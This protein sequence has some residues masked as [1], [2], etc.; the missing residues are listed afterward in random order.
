MP[1]SQAMRQRRPGMRVRV[2]SSWVANGYVSVQQRERGGRRGG[3]ANGRT[4]KREWEWPGFDAEQFQKRFH[5]EVVM[6][7]DAFEN[8]RKCSDFDGRMGRN[9]FVILAVGLRGHP[10]VRA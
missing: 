6:G 8:T 2:S 7:S 1:S 3:I 9:H 10:D 4:R 5:G